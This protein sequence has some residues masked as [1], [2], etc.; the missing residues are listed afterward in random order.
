MAAKVKLFDS[1][2]EKTWQN[3]LNLYPKVLKLKAEKKKKVGA[4]KEL[5]GLDNWY[6][7]NICTRIIWAIKEYRHDQCMAQALN[8]VI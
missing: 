1:T 2:C 3:A 4:Q 7:I 5:I 8:V 6:V